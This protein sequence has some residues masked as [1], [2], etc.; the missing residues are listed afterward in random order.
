MGLDAAHGTTATAHAA[1]AP[2]WLDALFLRPP[3]V[4]GR[5]VTLSACM[6]LAVAHARL[7]SVKVA[8]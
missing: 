1:A 8:V 3:P 7:P 4:T 2:G 5:P 6:Q